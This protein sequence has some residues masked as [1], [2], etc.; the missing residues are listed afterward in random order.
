MPPSLN[1]G[2]PLKRAPCVRITPLPLRIKWK[3]GTAATAPS[4]NGGITLQ[5]VSSVRV[6]YLP[7]IKGIYMKC[8]HKNC[9]RRNCNLTEKQHERDD[10]QRQRLREIFKDRIFKG[11]ILDSDFLIPYW[12]EE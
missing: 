12:P 3:I 5:K 6:R 2:V 10:K 9:Q 11:N 7:P 8:S 1:L 4:W